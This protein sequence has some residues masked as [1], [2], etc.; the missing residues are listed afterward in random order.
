MTGVAIWV[1]L[2]GLSSGALQTTP[3]PF[4][5]MY[6]AY[7][8]AP[9]PTTL[10]AG[11]LTGIKFQTWPSLLRRTPESDLRKNWPLAALYNP[12]PPPD[13]PTC[14]T[15]VALAALPLVNHNLACAA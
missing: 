13:L 4:A 6:P 2:V 10:V 12:P 3:A 14:S 1:Q 9:E 8:A 11:G 15:G 7:S 5:N